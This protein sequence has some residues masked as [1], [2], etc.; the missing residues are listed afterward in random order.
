[1]RAHSIGGSLHGLMAESCSPKPAPACSEPG[2]SVHTGLR[3]VFLP[4]VAKAGFTGPAE[5]PAVIRLPA[6]EREAGATD[7]PEKSNPGSVG[8]GSIVLICPG[9]RPAV[10]ALA[11]SAPLALTPILGKSLLEHWLDHLT[12]EGV[13][14]VCLVAS[15]RPEHLRTWL[16]DGVRWE[17]KVELIAEAGELTIAEARAK[18]SA[19]DPSDSR[20]KPDDVLVM[21]FLPGAPARQLF[22]SYADWFMAVTRRMPQAASAPDRIGVRELQAG[23]WAG[24][25][26]R[27]SPEAELRAPCWIGEKVLIGPRA[28]VGPDAIV[29]DGTVLAA[30]AEVANS[31]V[32]PG[33]YVGEFTEVKNSLASGSTLIN[34]QTGSCI[35]VPDAFLLSPLDQ[36]VITDRADHALGVQRISFDHHL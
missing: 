11:Q 15:D 14:R 31:I 32:G 36:R 23:V 20:T 18:Y 17:L 9:A 33:T 4:V 5:R 21:D 29:E 28:I 3:Q 27:I 35:Q 24:L 19:N 1:M 26:S 6:L 16:G 10:H 2:E 34:W 30:D 8:S 12:D 7:P 25:H 13:R 22:R